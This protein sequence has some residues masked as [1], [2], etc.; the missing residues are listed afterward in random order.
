[1]AYLYNLYFASIEKIIVTAISIIEN[2]I[3]SHWAKE[4]LLWNVPNK[5]PVE[6]FWI[7]SSY[8]TQAEKFPSYCSTE[9]EG[10]TAIIAV[11]RV[12]SI[13]QLSKFLKAS[14]LQSK[15]VRKIL[16]LWS[17]NN[18]I[19]PQ[20]VQI[21]EAHH[22]LITVLNQNESPKAAHWRFSCCMNESTM[23]TNDAI[24]QFDPESN[25]IPEE[26]LANR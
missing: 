6:P 12:I 11:S 3:H 25:L 17:L 22:S 21:A 26:V 13:F 14:L 19:A 8:S 23:S 9:N 7:D 10:F 18:L 15:Y 20:I 1:M 5:S 4:S 2:R 24:F 16:I